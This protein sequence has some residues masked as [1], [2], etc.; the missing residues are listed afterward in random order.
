MSSDNI[1]IKGIHLYA[2]LATKFTK[3][4]DYKKISPGPLKNVR[5][6]HTL[7]DI[8]F[9]CLSEKEAGRGKNNLTKKK[10]LLRKIVYRD[11]ARLFMI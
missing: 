9:D 3:T 7:K 8:S 10:F 11:I 5:G 1:L 6:Q 2:P 4:F